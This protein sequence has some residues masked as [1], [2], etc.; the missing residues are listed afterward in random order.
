MPRSRSW[1]SALAHA[2]GFRAPN[3]ASLS[4]AC[5]PAQAACARL[6]PTPVQNA[7][8]AVSPGCDP[9]AAP[10]R[11]HRIKHG[12]RRIGQRLRV[13]D[14]RGVAHVVSAAEEARSIGFEL[15]AADRRRP[16]SELKCAIHSWACPGSRG[17]RVASSAPRSRDEFG[18]HEH[19]GKCGMRGIAPPGRLNTTSDVRRQFDLARAASLDWSAKAAHFRIVLAQTR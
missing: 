7:T 4:R 13:H 10:Q 5:R 16:S 6:A 17:R 15:Q 19:L 8:R 18:L 9:H 11:Q 14:G 1:V 2:S 3:A 12:A